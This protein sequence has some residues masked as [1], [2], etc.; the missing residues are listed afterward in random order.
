MGTFLLSEER[1]AKRIFAGLPIT[2][3]VESEGQKFT[4]RSAVVG[5]SEL[6][7]RIRATHLLFPGQHAE[8]MPGKALRYAVHSRVVY[9]GQPA[10]PTNTT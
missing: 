5:L 3:L 7:A 8:I 9:G 1:T 4:H 2:L 10:S 6:G